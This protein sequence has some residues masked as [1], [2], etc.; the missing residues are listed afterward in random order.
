LACQRRKKG[1]DLAGMREKKKKIVKMEGG[2][3][4]AT[5][6]LWWTCDVQEDARIDMC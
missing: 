5:L 1:R 3:K 4:I 2:G 6:W